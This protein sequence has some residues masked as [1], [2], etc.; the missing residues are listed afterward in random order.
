MAKKSNSLFGMV[1]LAVVGY[2]VYENW[3]A[4]GAWAES[5]LPA[6]A[7]TAAP[8]SAGTVV[9]TAVTPATVATPAIVPATAGTVVPT[10]SP[11]QPIAI[12]P[13]ATNPQPDE[14]AP[15]TAGTLVLGPAVN[16]MNVEWQDVWRR[17]PV[18]PIILRQPI[19]Q[20]ANAATEV[21]S[22]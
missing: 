4:I 7:A 17:V 20:P 10:S 22:A 6:A 12:D 16:P 19:V 14:S 5:L 21:Y 2:A 3:A 1:A 9:A 8:A 18:S 13:T 15:A 11:A